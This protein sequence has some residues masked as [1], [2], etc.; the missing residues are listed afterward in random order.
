MIWFDNNIFF[1][2][3]WG[4]KKDMQIHNKL[5]F[6]GLFIFQK[7]IQEVKIICIWIWGFLSFILRKIKQNV[8][9]QLCL[10]FIISCF[11]FTRSSTMLDEDLFEEKGFNITPELLGRGTCDAGL[12][13]SKECKIHKQIY[14]YFVF[15]SCISIVDLFEQ[16][17]LQ[18]D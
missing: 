8:V 10:H 13:F 4:K 15:F 18:Q 5:Y 12:H 2:V 6:C 14:R 9:L 17:K 7:V 3:S 11:P 1:M 16:G